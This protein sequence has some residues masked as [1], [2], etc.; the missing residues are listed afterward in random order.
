MKS[1]T[2]GTAATAREGSRRRPFAAGD[3]ISTVGTIFP[4]VE[5]AA[6]DRRRFRADV[7]L[8][9]QAFEPMFAQARTDCGLATPVTLFSSFGPIARQTEER[10]VGLSDLANA[11]LRPSD[12]AKTRPGCE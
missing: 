2:R 1:F 9:F 8:I 3:F 7:F 10:R 12:P 6:G 11:A 4:A 5:R